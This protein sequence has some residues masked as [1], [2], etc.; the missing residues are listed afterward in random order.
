MA[1][2][3]IVEG[4]IETSIDKAKE[5]KKVLEPIITLSKEDNLHNRRSIASTLR[6]RHNSLTP[7][8]TR[9]AKE[10]NDKAYNDDRK[11]MKKLFEDFGPRYKDRHGG[12]LRLVRTRARVGDGAELCIVQCV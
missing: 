9:E 8:E 6:I 5:L 1:K 7:S 2:S 3:M 4:Q 12:Y 11:V 10:G